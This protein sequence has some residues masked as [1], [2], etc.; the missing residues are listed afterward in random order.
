M[1]KTLWQLFKGEMRAVSYSV[2]S[3]ACSPL[4]LVLNQKHFH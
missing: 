1:S 4:Y 3:I 2:Q